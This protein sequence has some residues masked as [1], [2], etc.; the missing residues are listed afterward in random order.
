VGGDLPESLS[1][2]QLLSQEVESIMDLSIML[3]THCSVCDT[4]LKRRVTLKE[5]MRSKLHQ[6]EYME[7]CR[8][9]LHEDM[10]SIRCG[11]MS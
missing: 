6:S 11:E 10:N 8:A 7:I 5:I 4:K 3:S 9:R 2:H 1:V